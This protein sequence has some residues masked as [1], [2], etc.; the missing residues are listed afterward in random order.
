MIKYFLT[1]ILFTFTLNCT[2][3]VLNNGDI[4]SYTHTSKLTNNL[5]LKFISRSSINIVVLDS[6]LSDLSLE[7]IFNETDDKTRTVLK[8]QI[9]GSQTVDFGD[10]SE[11]ES[12]TIVAL[13][14]GKNKSNHQ[15]SKVATFNLKEQVEIDDAKRRR[16][17]KN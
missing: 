16:G 13:L 17:L 5:E 4:H 15:I 12:G 1:L 9:T 10:L 6:S 8:K 14:K 7:I 2:N 3:K 11:F